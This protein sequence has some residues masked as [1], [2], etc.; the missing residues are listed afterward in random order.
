MSAQR[1]HNQLGFTVLE[2]L[3]AMSLSAWLLLTVI[4]LVGDLSQ[5]LH[6]QQ[7]MTDLMDRE[8]GLAQWLPQRIS[9]AGLSDCL[10][11]KNDRVQ[12][13]KGYGRHQ[14]A[15]RWLTQR[16]SQTDA[17]IISGC[18]RYR[19]KQQW[20]NTAYYIAKTHY[21]NEWGQPEYALYQKVEGGRREVLV[22]GIEDWSIH[23]ALQL[24]SDN[25]QNSWLL[26]SSV[27]DW[28]QVS[29]V[30]FNILVRTRFKMPHL[31]THYTWLGQIYTVP[32]GAFLTDV[33]ITV[34]LRE[35]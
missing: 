5:H 25:S 15:P 22:S 8:N 3:L 7:A 11:D 1:C 16:K 34:A 2:M 4:M 27:N 21:K 17:V 14:S 18:R 29:L 20:I 10:K 31:R 28:R 26:A 33:I 9:Q 35:L 13:I 12:V 32:K 19:G 23:Y 24:P 30:S 6:W